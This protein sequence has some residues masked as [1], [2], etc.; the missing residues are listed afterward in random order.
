MSRRLLALNV[1]LG[2]LCVALLAASVRAIV[3]R[4]P[5]PPAVTTRA[6]TA[7]APSP[8]TA[9]PDPGPASYGAIASRN[10]FSPARS[11]TAVAIAPTSRPI[12]HGV[13]IDGRKSRAFLEDPAAKRVL[14]YSVG[15]VFG[16]GKIQRIT[17]DRVVIL[18][19]EGPL[20]VLLM[21][22][23]KPRPAPTTVAAP[24]GGP[25]TPP[26]V[27]TPQ[28]QPSAQPPTSLQSPTIAPPPPAPGPSPALRR[29]LR[30]EGND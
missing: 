8:A 19:P 2:V 24:P 9:T 27:V 30:G 1:V 29:R 28:G 6:M 21:D 16:N 23:T 26:V 7:P 4:R 18:R 10:V 11:E 25:A 17:D 14:G 22:P 13:V 15:D 20:E 12:L 3:V 5:L